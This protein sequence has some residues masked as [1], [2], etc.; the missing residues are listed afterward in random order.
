MNNADT[1]LALIG[2]GRF[3]QFWARHLSHHF[4]VYCF[5]ANKHRM[6]ESEVFAIPDSLENCLKKPYIFLTLPIHSIPDFLR[7]NRKK[8]QAGTV[9]IDCASVKEIILEWFRSYIPEEV[10]YVASHP[11]FGPDS[12]QSGLK[13]HA[14]TLIPGRVPFV[15]YRFL[16]DLFKIKLELTVLNMTA[17]EHDRMMAYNLSLMHHIGRTFDRMKIS[18]I[19]LVMSNLQKI[20]TMSEIVMRDSD[21]LFE[22]FYKLNPYAGEI[23]DDF[24]TQFNIITR[25]VDKEKS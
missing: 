4:P 2:M 10:S 11:L 15:H 20:K 21:E 7:K 18:R 12:A 6:Q 25:N 13:G 22:D 9:I 1:T 14:V 24:M 19:P 16:V 17:V 23:R 8:M 5:D 3:G